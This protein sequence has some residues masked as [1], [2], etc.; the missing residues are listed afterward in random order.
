MMSW[1]FTNGH[2]KFDGFVLFQAASGSFKD[3]HG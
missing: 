1:E 2:G 3:S